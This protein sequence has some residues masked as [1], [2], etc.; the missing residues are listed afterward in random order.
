MTESVKNVRSKIRIEP[1]F[2]EKIRL[3]RRFSKV[4]GRG[5]RGPIP[6]PLPLTRRGGCGFGDLGR[7]GRLRVFRDIQQEIIFQDKI[8]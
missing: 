6:P 2:Y 7:G 3:Q 8:L 4:H 5:R 1:E